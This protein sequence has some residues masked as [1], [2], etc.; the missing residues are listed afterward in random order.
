MTLK[1]ILSDCIDISEYIYVVTGGYAESE[2]ELLSEH[3]RGSP[4][5][6][7]TPPA[8]PARSMSPDQQEVQQRAY[9]IQFNSIQRFYFILERQ[10]TYMNVNT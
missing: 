10:D 3:R 4:V 9:S 1:Q 6:C 8:K 2:P 5:R 7:S